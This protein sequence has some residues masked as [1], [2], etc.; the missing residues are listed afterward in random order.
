MVEP[1]LAGLIGDV[2]AA[3]QARG[4]APIPVTDP[5]GRQWARAYVLGGL[6]AVH[7]SDPVWLA[8]AEV[9][10]DGS[11]RMVL[12]HPVLV[13]GTPQHPLPV[14][15]PS[16][17]TAYEQFIRQVM[18]TNEPTGGRV[19][20]TTDGV[21]MISETSSGTIPLNDYLNSLVLGVAARNGT[22][23]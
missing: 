16:L 6:Q 5:G 12:D 7:D 9:V 13:S 21:L 19:Y 15:C 2:V 3:L 10:L 23:S 18:I 22:P 11:G 17:A 8:Q 4:K 20:R 14:S 1:V